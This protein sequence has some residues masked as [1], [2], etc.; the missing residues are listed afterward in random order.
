MAVLL[1]RPH[2]ITLFKNVFFAATVGFQNQQ[3][4]VSEGATVECCVLILSGVIMTEFQHT[5][6]VV[7]ISHTAGLSLPIC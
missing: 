7:P 3:A 2:K 5:L 6:H 4:I 1:I